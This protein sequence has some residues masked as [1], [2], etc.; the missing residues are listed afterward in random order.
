MT[1]YI[2]KR[3]FEN[4]L[5]TGMLLT[6]ICF[7]VTLVY[8]PIWGM[9]VKTIASG[10]AGSGLQSVDAPTAAKYLGVFT[11]GTFFW[12]VINAWIWLFLVFGNYGKNYFGDRQPL[13]G[14]WY[15][16]VGLVAGIIGFLVLVGFSGIWW[17]P[18]SLAILFTPKTAEEVRLAIEGWEVSNFYAVPVIIGQI[19]YVA[20][21]QKWP[22]AGNIK[23]PWDGFGAMMTSTVFA[24]IIWFA[25]FIPSL[26]SGLSLGGHSILVKPF[27][28]WPTFL[29][30]C[31][32]FIFMFLIPAEGGER[33][34]Q[35][36]FAQNQPY[37]G[38][39][40]L[41]IAIVAALA[42]PPVLRMIVSPFDLLPGAPPDLVVASLVLS[43]VT[44]LL[45]WHHL[46]DDYPSAAIV[47]NAALRFFSRLAIWL[48]GGVLLGVIWLK[49]FKVLPFGGNNMG[50]GY[51]AMGVLAGQFAFMMVFLYCNTFF[52]KWPLVRKIPVAAESKDL[53]VKG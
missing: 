25:M 11:E 2:V 10:L 27:G 21:F 12:M 4:P 47:P 20:L 45:L 41:I 6:V 44:F 37:A 35:K 32:T 18:F 42:I 7:V 36:L 28:G 26:M 46:F 30:F 19:S 52:D 48:V 38:F 17:K 13:A 40:G 9:L 34:P 50:M 22:F 24:L 29:A 43:S 14:I 51:S 1:E 53:N 49:T 39:I 23:A 16:C 8:W 3:R 33:Y 5:V 31:Q 15:S